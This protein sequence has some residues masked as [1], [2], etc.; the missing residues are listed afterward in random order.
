ML[1]GISQKNKQFHNVKPSAY[2]FYMKTKISV[3]FHI[4]ISVP[5]IMRKLSQIFVQEKANAYRSALRFAVLF[6]LKLKYSW[7]TLD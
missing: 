5:L 6:F 3:E 7:G 1:G 2:H 4:C